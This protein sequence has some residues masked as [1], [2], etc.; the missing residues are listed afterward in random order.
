MMDRS[1]AHSTNVIKM[2]FKQYRKP[3]YNMTA[4]VVLLELEGCGACKSFRQSVWPIICNTIENNSY[5]SSR[6]VTVTH[7]YKPAIN[8]YTPPLDYSSMDGISGQSYPILLVMGPGEDR[9]P[10]KINNTNLYPNR[11]ISARTIKASNVKVKTSPLDWTIS[12]LK[13]K[14]QDYTAPPSPPTKKKLTPPSRTILTEYVH[15]NNR[16][17]LKSSQL[18]PL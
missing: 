4:R 2:E 14:L 6:V 15:P 16:S 17:N 12:T 8:S 10:Y 11:V 13:Q 9:L 5:L 7:L 1:S 18:T 3:I